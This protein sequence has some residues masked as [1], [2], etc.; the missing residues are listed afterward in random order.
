VPNHYLE[1]SLDRTFRFLAFGGIGTVT[2]L[3]CVELSRALWQYEHPALFALLPTVA[4]AV[5]IMAT[6][7]FRF[8]RDERI[9]HGIML[10][11]GLGLLASLVP[12][13]IF[14]DEQSTDI[15]NLYAGAFSAALFRCTFRWS[16][17]ALQGDTLAFKRGMGWVIMTFAGFLL[18]GVVVLPWLSHIH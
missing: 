8:A 7:Y 4:Y 1:N 13:M 2:G 10:L 12:Y 5:L 14:R 3:A 15:L 17:R 9:S 16:R 6:I 18:F 11:A